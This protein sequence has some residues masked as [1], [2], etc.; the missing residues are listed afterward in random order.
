MTLSVELSGLQ[1]AQTDLD[2]IGNNIANVGTDG[3]KASQANFSD[4]YGNSLLGTAGTAGTPGQ[5]VMTSSL[6]QLFT[7]GSISTTGNPLNVA[8]NGNGFFQVLTPT[9]VAYSRDGSFGLDAKG[10]LV[11]D[12]GSFVMGFSAPASGSTAVAAGTLGKLQIN[13]ANVPAAATSNLTMSLNLP[14]TDGPINTT[15]TPFSVNAPASYNQSTTSTVFDSLGTPRTLTT[16]FTEV[17]GSGA[18]PQWQTHWALSNS[19]GTM[20]GSGSGATLSFNSSG[21]LTGGTGTINVATLPDGAAPLSIAQSFTGTT[22]TD[23]NFGVNSIQSN[24]TSAGQFSGV[25][26]DTNGNV[27]AQYSNGATKIQGTVALVSFTNPQGLTPISG[28]NWLATTASGQPLTN[29]PGSAGVGTLESGALEGSN[30]DLSTQLVNLIVAQQAYQA[31]VQGI[32]VD[33]QDVQKL[34]TIQ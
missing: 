7:E 15:T 2:T 33:Q 23:L 5:G 22:L 3:F 31:N 21:A 9:G 19:D 10:D 20:V 26:I 18:P 30:V 29:M 11:N 12:A 28:N 4:L 13:E 6:S 24:G 8:I 17:S 14:S 16:Y 32:N 27:V 25:S 34:M 1:A